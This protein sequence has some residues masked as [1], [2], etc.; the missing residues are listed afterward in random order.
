M[1]RQ[2]WHSLPLRS[3]DGEETQIYDLVRSLRVDY[4]LPEPIPFRQYQKLLLQ[5]LE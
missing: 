4:S 2:G 5:R 3:E 1:V